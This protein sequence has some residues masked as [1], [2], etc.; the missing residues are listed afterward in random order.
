VCARGLSV[1]SDVPF[2]LKTEEEKRENSEQYL[3]SLGRDVQA[4]YRVI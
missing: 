1:D 2:L 3:S 4:L